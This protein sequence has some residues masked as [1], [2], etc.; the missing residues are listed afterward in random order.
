VPKAPLVLPEDVPP[1]DNGD[2]TIS[3]RTHMFSRP[4]AFGARGSGG[5]AYS[6]YYYLD[7]DCN[8]TG[9]LNVTASNL[10]F[11]QNVPMRVDWVRV[12]FNESEATAALARIFKLH[13]IS[14]NV[15]NTSRPVI[16]LVQK[17]TTVT[18]RMPK[19][20][21]YGMIPQ[22]FKVISTVVGGF[23]GLVTAKVSHNPLSI[24]SSLAYLGMSPDS[25]SV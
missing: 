6:R 3:A 10:G 4:R 23:K 15:V 9:A 19:S 8:T 1:T 7:W 14:G 2:G 18:I 21:D 20:A 5:G 13:D 16:G 12:V 22:S 24:I 25:A 11:P 17:F